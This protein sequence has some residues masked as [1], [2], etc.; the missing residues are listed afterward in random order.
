MHEQL[1]DTCNKHNH[2]ADHDNN[3]DKTTT[4][5]PQNTTKSAAEILADAKARMEAARTKVALGG[6]FHDLVVSK[7]QIEKRYASVGMQIIPHATEQTYYNIKFSGV[8]NC[9][10]ADFDGERTTFVPS[11]CW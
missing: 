7:G 9:F 11:A 5:G 8:S 4:T 10:E 1:I 2:R 6:S 3:V